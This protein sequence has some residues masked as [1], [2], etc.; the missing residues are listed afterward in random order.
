MNVAVLGASNKPERYS[1]Q[2]VKLLEE[3][4]HRVFPV[5]PRIQ[6]IDQLGVYPSIKDIPDPIHTVSLYVAA[7][8]SSMIAEDILAKH[9]KR[10]I[11]NSGAE[12]K[13]LAAKALQAGIQALE[14]CTLVLLRTGQF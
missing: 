9:P 5:H 3:K 8:I 6:K 7:N 11:F 14:A 2:A 4:G 12:N 13:D 1:Y 10:I